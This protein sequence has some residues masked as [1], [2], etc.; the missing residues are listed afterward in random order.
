MK[1]TRIARLRALIILASAL[2]TTCLWYNVSGKEQDQEQRGSPHVIAM[3]LRPFVAYKADHPGTDLDE[4]ARMRAIKDLDKFIRSIMEHQTEG[5]IGGMYATYEG[6][7]DTFDEND[8]LLFPRKHV[9]D[10][11][12]IIVTRYIYPV[13]LKGNTV[14][15]FVRQKDA[16]IVYYKLSRFKDKDSG[17]FFWKTEKLETPRDTK[18]PLHAIVLCANPDEIIVPE[19]ITKTVGGPHLILPAMYP[20]KHI[21]RTQNALTFLKINKYF[22][23]VYMT[24]KVQQDRYASIMNP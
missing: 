2:G 18:I 15:Y 9:E 3:F 13:I 14:E 21:K 10:E 19:G 1:P 20:A 24:Y 11:V 4:V 17:D 7:V 16:P 8:E 12:I 5:H 6:F 22:S 23:P